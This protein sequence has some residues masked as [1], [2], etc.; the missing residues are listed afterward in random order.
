MASVRPAASVYE[1]PSTAGTTPPVVWNSTARSRTSGSASALIARPDPED[2]C[3]PVRSC[4]RP[5]LVGG[6]S[7]Q[8]RVERVAE[9]VAEDDERQHGD[10]QAAERE[11]QQVR[12]P[13]GD[14]L[15]AVA[16]H[17]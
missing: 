8:S 9:R 14:P 4:W 15:G 5:P 10:D 6:R 16:D 17:D 12:V 3:V 1:R 11:Q 7:S 2:T 13:A